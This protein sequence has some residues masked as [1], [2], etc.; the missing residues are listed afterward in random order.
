MTLVLLELLPAMSNQL[1][2]AD[3]RPVL[4]LL[5]CACRIH[6]MWSAGHERVRLLPLMLNVILVEFGAMVCVMMLNMPLTGLKL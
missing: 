6:P 3:K 1:P 4:R 5:V 2:T